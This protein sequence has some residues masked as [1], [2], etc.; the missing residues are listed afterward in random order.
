MSVIRR[1]IA[2]GSLFCAAVLVLF[3]GCS[4]SSSGGGTITTTGEGI[5]LPAEVSAVA[6]R[7]D[8]GATIRVG[9]INGSVGAA[10]RSYVGTAQPAV[11]DLPEGSDYH[12]WQVRKFVDIK[13]LD[14]FEIID[15]IFDAMRQTGYTDED[16]VGQGWY[17]TL[18][19]FKDEG[20][21]GRTE[22]S[23]QEWY[24][25]SQLVV[26]GGQTTNRV[27]VKI[28]END[29]DFE[30]L[31][32]VQVDV[33][34]APTENEDGTLADLG[35]WEIR[36]S[37][38]PNDGTATN[39]GFFHATG[40]IAGDDTAK[41]TISD[42]F[43]RNEGPDDEEITSET[44][45]VIYRS[46]EE[47]YGS[48]EVP[49]W[50]QCFGGGPGG[51]GDDEDDDNPCADGTVPNVEIQFS[52][53]DR[54]LSVT[55]DEDTVS[56]DRADEHELVYR[57]E[58]FDGTTGDL[59]QKETEF[60]FPVRGGENNNQHG[61][62]GSWQDRHELWMDGDTL[63]TGATVVRDGFFQGD[64]PPSYTV[65]RFPGAL[66]KIGLVEGS[67]DQLENIAAEIFLF[68][69][70]RLVW[71]AEGQRWERCD[72]EGEFGGCET[73]EDFTSGL[74]TL[75][76]R[77]DGDQKHINVHSCSF[78]EETEEFSC[79][80]YVYQETEEGGAF[81]VAQFDEQTG[82]LVPTQ[83]QLTPTDGQELW[84]SIGGRTYIQYTGEFD[85]ETTTTGWV[86]K[87]L[88]EFNFDTWTPVFN[89]EGDTE[90]F[91]EN[92]REY[93]VNN[94]GANLRVRRNGDDGTAEDFEV[95]MEVQTVAKPGD[96]L[97]TLY[98]EGTVLVDPWD[99]EFSSRYTF[100][101]DPASDN[102]L[103]LVFETVNE[104][105]QSEGFSAGDVVTNK[106]IW[107]L[108][109]V[110]DE[111]SF[112][113]ATL[114]N[115]EYRGEGDFF[116]GVTYLRDS[117]N[118]LVLLSEPIRFQPVALPRT[119]DIVNDR[120]EEEWLTYSLMFDG[121]LHGLPDT[122]YELQKVDFEG[123]GITAIL[124]NNVRIAD[125]L[126]LTSDDGDGTYLVKGV[127]VGIF[128]G[129]VTDFPDGEQPDMTEATGL[130]LD[131]EIP[132]FTHPDIDGTVP[133]AELLYVEGIPVSELSE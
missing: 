41:L 107:G 14:V 40:S 20:E 119:D 79:N 33:E 31:I 121:F 118:E 132:E 78:N 94:R 25:N 1:H 85:G 56:F 126:E 105:D 46:E 2:V 38:G 44:R 90:F 81:F 70:F 128:L 65:V 10:L 113:E 11:A 60:G 123:D 102:Y 80:D 98:P 17:K 133:D 36:A 72:G 4:D 26:S 58:L 35:V 9:R 104:T 103:L 32:R 28:V 53:N 21:G 16:N 3:S 55:V 48:V 69:D 71:N 127:D 116:G 125:G 73:Q 23:L 99:P 129:F 84:V 8:A 68:N 124:S 63:E 54:Y 19:A 87:E 117:D 66:T 83:T 115:W 88:S 34:E 111:S 18:V 67:L 76:Q 42:S 74:S 22:T 130:D 100:E 120:A 7:G 61:Y 62:Y 82:Q 12:T 97:A 108:R 50:D 43:T 15:T 122:N 57:Y 109:I 89:D 37:F 77:G 51:P 92:G 64:E 5:E 6:A 131:E 114:F 52:Y 30:Q 49:D 91:F 27:T 112:E 59:V 29:E 110:G 93:F 75:V 96:D 39:T 101:T 13:V 86:E 106:D 95:Y 45:A 47:G 24:V